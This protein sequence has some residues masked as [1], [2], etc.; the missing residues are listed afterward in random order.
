MDE[1]FD[2]YI[3]NIYIKIKRLEDIYKDV[4]KIQSTKQTDLNELDKDIENIKNDINSK[5]EEIRNN[6]LN[7]KYS[8]PKIKLLDDYIEQLDKHREYINSVIEGQKRKKYFE[9][10]KKSQQKRVDTIENKL[11]DCDKYER[12][13]NEVES[14]YSNL[15]QK[16]DPIGE[17]TSIM[18][19]RGIG[20]GDKIIITAETT[21]DGRII[22]NSVEINKETN[23]IDSVTMADFRDDDDDNDNDND[24]NDND[25]DDNDN[26]D[27]DLHT[28]YS[29]DSIESIYNSASTIQ[30]QS[31][32]ES[33]IESEGLTDFIENI[34]NI[35]DFSSEIYNKIH[36]H[37]NSL[38]TKILKT[39]KHLKFIDSV[40]KVITIF[41]IIFNS[42]NEYLMKIFGK[43]DNRFYNKSN[44]FDIELTNLQS[45]KKHFEDK[46][47]E[48][49]DG[50][51][52][53]EL[54]KKANYNDYINI[55]KK[56]TEFLFV[57]NE[58]YNYLDKEVNEKKALLEKEIQNNNNEFE[59][60]RKNINSLWNTLVIEKGDFENIYWDI[61]VMGSGFSKENSTLGVGQALSKGLYV[62]PGNNSQPI[63]NIDNMI[64]QYKLKKGKSRGGSTIKRHLNKKYTISKKI[65]NARLNKTRN[66]NIRNKNKNKTNRL[67]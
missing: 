29:D 18:K 54:K 63:S 12:F 43:I 27:N 33:T 50:Y 4:S 22:D 38:N 8:T 14:L 10:L 45:K 15:K 35:K 53:F 61:F 30:D 21:D 26:D 55:I 9:L 47:K 36:S 19:S 11:K 41:S 52:L 66:R 37:Y 23:T 6:P 34:K 32:T 51:N 5:K 16:Y 49:K 13:Y 65:K 31:S 1:I 67:I 59:L 56:E 25:D 62:T 64:R 3:K 42:I 46:Y 60:Y 40:N 28:V 57:I 20:N 44:N 48:Y 2:E 7:D 39:D 17:H 58:I 24:D